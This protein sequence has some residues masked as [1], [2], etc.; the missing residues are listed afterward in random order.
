MHKQR[1]EDVKKSKDL[2]KMAKEIG[3][4]LERKKN[5]RQRNHEFLLQGIPY[6]SF[7]NLERSII[8]NREN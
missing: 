3:S 8:I 7:T 1:L 2:S 5:E 4:E 6:Y